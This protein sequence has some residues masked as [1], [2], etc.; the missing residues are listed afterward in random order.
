MISK[1]LTNQKA[2]EYE[3]S[4]SLTYLK[5][6][7]LQIEAFKAGVRWCLDELNTGYT[8]VDEL[9]NEISEIYKLIN[10]NDVEESY[11][12]NLRQ[13]RKKLNTLSYNVRTLNHK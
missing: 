11:K 3:N 4:I 8:N 13:A 10:F 1:E 6:S 7:E 2:K 5:T 9:T 12:E